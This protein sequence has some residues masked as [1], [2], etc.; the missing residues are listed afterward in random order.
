MTG[1][2][3]KHLIER[4]FLG[5]VP[6]VKFNYDQTSYS[7]EKVQFLLKGAD[8]G[9]NFRPNDPTK[10][11]PP[12]QV[13]TGDPAGMPEIK[14]RFFKKMLTVYDQN[15]EYIN[16]LKAVNND[17]KI[18]TFNYP[19][20]M[21]LG[22]LGID[23]LSIMNKV[24]FHMKKSRAEH[25]GHVPIA[26]PLPPAEWVA[27]PMFPMDD[28]IRNDVMPNT[29]ERVMS[30]KNFVVENKKK[31]QRMFRASR[32]ATD[33]YLVELSDSLDDVHERIKTQYE[34]EDY[35]ADAEDQIIE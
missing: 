21:N 7:V 12:T 29:D 27:P 24:L 31:R 3:H 26:D 28:P 8:Y 35:P 15:V 30:M 25:R 5:R 19:A 2:L 14:T 32:N 10:F 11:A 9:K 33:K 20:D 4:N 17:Y 16:S 34:E 22:M 6:I 1:A 23:Y 18:P 13:L